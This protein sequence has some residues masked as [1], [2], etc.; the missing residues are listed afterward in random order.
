[1]KKMMQMLSLVVLVMAIC[2]GVYAA[3]EPVISVNGMTGD[4]SLK[5]DAPITISL[6]LSPGEKKGADADWWLVCY[7]S[8]KWY[9]YKPDGKLTEI[10]DISSIAPAYQGKLFEVPAT[11][12]VSI[13]QL[14]VGNYTLIFGVDLNMNGKVD[15]DSLVVKTV[16]IAVSESGK[17]SDFTTAGAINY[18]GDGVT[19]VF[20]APAKTDQTTEVTRAI[21]EADII[22]V[23]GNYLYLL[24]QYKGLTI[25]DMSKPDSP[26]IAGRV[27]VTGQPI[28]MYIRDSRAYI[29]VSAT[30]QTIYKIA[31]DGT[32]SSTTAQGSRIQVADISDKTNPKLAGSFDLKGRVTDSRIVGNIL[33]AVSSEQ[34][35]YYWDYAVNQSKVSEQNVYVASIDISDPKNIR[36]ADR[37]DFGG[38]ARYIHVTDQ[39]IFIAS[40]SDYY[41]NNNSNITYLDISDPAGKM[42]KRGS[43][44]LPGSVNDKFKMDYYNGYFRVCTYQWNSKGISFLF[45]IDVK[46]PDS[47]KQVGSVKLGEGEQLFATRFDGNRAYMVTYKMK[48]PLWVIDLSDPAN[49]AVKGELIVPGW[50]TY[51]EPKGDR[52]IA[53]GVDDENGWKVSVSLFDVSKP[54]KPGLIKRVSFGDKDSGWSSSTAYND[55]KA[56]TVLEDSGLILLPYT[57]SSDTDGNYKTENRLQLIDYSAADLNT[58]G[59]ISQKGSVLRSR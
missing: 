13:P 32:T 27:A 15:K 53:L 35:V 12:I 51:I 19:T 28:D 30:Y 5:S 42:V 25:C 50:S 37:K 7:V 48:D 18:A 16:N 10:S 36:E 9:Y 45:V 54:E 2:T 14:P 21:E 33:Y 1:M 49:P 46:N 4:V 17:R 41:G 31:A 59:W 40:G 20:S 44:D 29:I 8:G 26:S 23:E 39:A 43:I 24:N 6:K 34:P 47:P 3:P 11:D 57:T 55:V 58:R 52:L 38:T 56:F 22:K